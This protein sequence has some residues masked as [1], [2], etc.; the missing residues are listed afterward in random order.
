MFRNNYANI[1]SSN[2]LE[3]MHSNQQHLCAT[4]L[5]F[6]F[7]SLPAG[8][9]Y[10]VQPSLPTYV[11]IHIWISGRC[12][13]GGGLLRDGNDSTQVRLMP[14]KIVFL[15][16]CE[17]CAARS[18]RSAASRPRSGLLSGR[19]HAQTRPDPTRLTN[20]GMTTK[21]TF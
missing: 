11:R 16:V 15:D 13:S 6:L 12:V 9:S 5:I 10:F 20:S 17:F 4:S 3:H 14:S 1:C 21:L 18:S 2:S 7:V 8:M 19:T